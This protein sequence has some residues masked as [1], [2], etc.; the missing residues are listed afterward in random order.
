MQLPVDFDLPTSGILCNCD[1]DFTAQSAGESP[2]R[3]VAD[4]LSTAL[5]AGGMYLEVCTWSAHNAAKATA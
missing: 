3:V 4:G 2:P 5:F 1:S